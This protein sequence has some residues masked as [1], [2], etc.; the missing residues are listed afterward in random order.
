MSNLFRE[1][2]YKILAEKYKTLYNRII[3]R[4]LNAT[5]YGQKEDRLK[6]I[7]TI[8]DVSN[9]DKTGIC[10]KEEST[11]ISLLEYLL[12]DGQPVK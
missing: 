1:K 8:V 11:T 6:V 5:E 4:A 9:Q 10:S 12:D 7:E 3:T 2:A